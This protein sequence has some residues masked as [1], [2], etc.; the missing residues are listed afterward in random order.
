MLEKKTLF[1]I[2]RPINFIF[3]DPRFL[4]FAEFRTGIEK[5]SKL[6]KKRFFFKTCRKLHMAASTLGNETKRPISDKIG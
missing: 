3:F 2:F 5:C 1:S 4:E 6:L